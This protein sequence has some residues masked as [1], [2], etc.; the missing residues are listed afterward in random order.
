MKSSSLRNHITFQLHHTHIHKYTHV[1][2]AY[3]TF[4]RCAQGRQAGAGTVAASVS[5]SLCP[6]VR[7]RR[8]RQAAASAT[9]FYEYNSISCQG[10]N[11]AVAAA[12]S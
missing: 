2:H 1:S 8:R 12:A 9:T 4:N 7:R 10:D 11:N 5:L 6:T 3:E